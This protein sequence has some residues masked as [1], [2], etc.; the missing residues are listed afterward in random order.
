MRKIVSVVL[1]LI[2]VFSLAYI[3]STV[4][5]TGDIVELIKNGD[6]E[7]GTNNWTGMDDWT[8][9]LSNSPVE[10]G[11]NSSHSFKIKTAYNFMYQAVTLEKDVTYTLSF[12]SK[13]TASQLSEIA[14]LTGSDG[15]GT[16]LKAIYPNTDDTDWTYYSFQYTSTA[17]QTACVRVKNI[18][19]VTDWDHTELAYNDRLFDDI[20]LTYEKA[21]EEDSEVGE[22]VENN[23]VSNSNFENGVEHWS[24]NTALKAVANGYSGDALE[25][26]GSTDCY[27]E[28]LLT[29]NKRY[30]V[31]F[32]YKSDYE[33]SF[34]I[35][36]RYAAKETDDSIISAVLPAS[37]SWTKISRSF[38]VKNVEHLRL[39]FHVAGGKV[40][41]VDNVAVYPESDNLVANGDFESGIEGWQGSSAGFTAVADGYSGKNALEIKNTS[42][43]T[44]YRKFIVKPNT[45]Y[46]FKCYIKGIVPA[47]QSIEALIGYTN[48]PYDYMN[49][50]ADGWI[51]EN[52][53]AA[54]WKEFT[55]A[56]NSA[57]H[58]ELYIRFR[59][60]GAALN[61]LVDDISVTEK[62]DSAL[63]KNGSF[64][65]G[66]NNWSMFNN[67]DTNNREAVDKDSLSG[68]HA[69]KMTGTSYHNLYQ[70]VTLKTNTNYMFSFYRKETNKMLRA[71]VST[72]PLSGDTKFIEDWPPATD[73]WTY[74]SYVFNSGENETAYVGFRQESAT[75]VSPVAI[76]D[77]VCLV[78]LPKV[79]IKSGIEGGT[80]NYAWTAYGMLKVTVAPNSGYQLKADSLT[81]TNGEGDTVAITD[82]GS[83]TN[84]GSGNGLKYELNIAED[85]TIN[86]EFIPVSQ[87][88]ISIVSTEADTSSVTAKT[89]LYLTANDKINVGGTEYAILES[90]TAVM[91]TEQLKGEELT[92]ETPLVRTVKNEILFD[93]TN[94]SSGGQRFIDFTAVIKNIKEENRDKQ[95]SFRS[96]V[97]YNDGTGDKVIYSNQAT[98]APYI[99]ENLAVVSSSS[100]IF[101]AELGSPLFSDRLWCIPDDN[102]LPDYLKES[103]YVYTGIAGSKVTVEKAGYVVVAHPAT[104]AD[105][106]NEKLNAEGF[107]L[108][109]TNM[110]ILGRGEKGNS[111]LSKTNYSIRWCEAGEVIDFSRP[112]DMDAYNE[113]CNGRE[114][115]QWYVIFADSQNAVDQPWFTDIA[116]FVEGNDAIQAS[117]FKTEKRT[118][119]GVTSLQAVKTQSGKTRL[120]GTWVTGGTGEP[121]YGNYDIFVYSDDE[122][123]TWNEFLAI[124]FT[125]QSESRINDAQFW[126]DPDGNMWIYY[127][128]SRNMPL[129]GK[130]E[131][132]WA[133]K[134]NNYDSDN[135]DNLEYSEPKIQF[136]GL[137]RNRPIVIEENGVET[138]L[139]VPNPLH[140]DEHYVPVYQ[141]VDK[142][143]TWT[144]RSTAY[145]NVTKERAWESSIV[146]LSDG[147]LWMI[148]RGLSGYYLEF[149]SSDKGKTWTDAKLGEI[150]DPATR[151]YAMNLSNGYIAIMHHGVNNAREKM[152][153]S[154]Y[155]PDGSKLKTIPIY[156]DICSYPDMVELDGKIWFMFDHNRLKNDATIFMGS[157]NINEILQDGYTY[158]SENLIQVSKIGG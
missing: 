26:T 16:T 40:L 37:G 131:Y 116:S 133:V 24:S 61:V 140:I 32:W 145:Q 88:N 5:A 128:Q 53:I 118:W 23:V 17:D 109:T 48:N 113:V 51:N 108:T 14:L 22:T 149:F 33:T 75:N 151:A 2:L 72:H 44:L 158:N 68:T 124:G 46:V 15:T 84:K 92:L 120:F 42:G 126:I 45:D 58:K 130:D 107:S 94:I 153:L 155:N 9:S 142:G 141:S 66:I 146:E 112:A 80:V 136:P 89:R 127:V 85:I 25:I 43:A 62:V 60:C 98:T 20:S 77:D 95:Y 4:F 106:L 87:E 110:P 81:Y 83:R 90:G 91:L 144:I 18:I 49:K 29:A 143:E 119:Q 52:A 21:A 132:T 82:I 65:D 71:Y 156:S 50:V 41:L 13:G 39:V 1:S 73:N 7:D 31:S 47:G 122:G 12:Y 147:R 34:Q 10:E 150:P 135:I 8:F 105:E 134:V 103:G 152:V 69:L 67:S 123:V 76:I 74:Q 70:K 125:R 86:A 64:E 38:T 6:A 111:A 137:L 57:E 28:L 35:R 99:K 11:H 93:E 148:S 114:D 78:E 30:T 59:Q 54:D 56:F 97:K 100:R 63:L 79:E 139:A 157:V 36:D 19:T 102:A 115:E 96:Y 129:F 101:R 154:I 27:T 3:P 117:E 55:F 104:G 121:I 138:W